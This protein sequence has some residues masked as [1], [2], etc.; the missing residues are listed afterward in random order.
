MRNFFKAIRNKYLL[1]VIVVL[2]LL[3]IPFN[4]LSAQEISLFKLSDISGAFILKY[5]STSD[6]DSFEGLVNSD[7]FRKYFEGGIQINSSGSIYHPNLLTFNI[8]FS[9][10]GYRAK[11]TLFSDS[12]IN[13]SVN[14]T[15]NIVLNLFKKKKIHFD[16]FAMKGF[17]TSDRNYF[18]RK[19]LLNESIGFAISNG[20]KLLPFRL[21]AYQSKSLSESISYE[22]RN[23]ESKNIE[24]Y[25]DLARIKNGKLTLRS[26]WKDFSEKVYGLNFQ[27]FDIRNDFSYFY[28]KSKRN[29]VISNVSYRK[30]T[31][32]LSLET[33]S[34][35]TNTS[36]F[37]RKGLFSLNIF[38]YSNDLSN[39]NSY[40]K[41]E[42]IS[43]LRHKLFDSLTTTASL[44]G[45]LENS[46]SQDIKSYKG[47]LTVNYTKKI[48]NGAINLNLGKSIENRDFISKSDISEV[49][50]FRKFTF[51]DTI[52][53][54]IPGIQ[55]DSI[56]ITNA[57]L[58]R[59]Y[60]EYIDYEITIVD[61]VINILR[62]PGGA[63]SSGEKVAIYYHYQTFPD[64]ELRN[65]YTQISASLYFLKYFHLFYRKYDNDMFLSS[66]YLVQPYEDFE[67]E[68]YGFRVDARLVNCEYMIDRYSSS[69]SGYR[70]RYFRLNSGFGF[71]K[72]FK[73]SGNFI[74]KITHYDNGNLRGDYKLYMGDL[75]FNPRHGVRFNAIYRYLSNK[76][77][78]YLAERESLII[79]F[80]W[81]IRKVVIDLFFEHFLN[82]YYLANKKHTYFSIIIRR[83][84]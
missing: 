79:K 54:S 12:D 53:L 18:E 64:H 14:N 60:I 40:Q 58:T 67:S 11:R 31:E 47:Q 51:S 34:F 41:G 3:F 37:I 56:R 25:S 59:I 48:K 49:S 22:E 62:I 36:N 82:D 20:T 72:Y 68:N 4:Y 42:L 26:N 38:S 28:G 71:L 45:R 84:F 73:F 9:L 30:M 52:L 6:I 83:L 35:T 7:I 5:E 19:Y 55:V 63:M 74:S 50:E 43:S 1:K 70:S 17:S 57:D 8:N 16:I 13:N 69:F 10:V 15:Y 46:S 81:T 75:T 32:D 29:F 33:L 2:N 80:N 65:D 77:S 27:S 39:N 76:T 61:N 78:V 24:F 66:E 21:K 23:E 44:S